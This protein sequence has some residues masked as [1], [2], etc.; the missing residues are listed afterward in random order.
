MDR[1]AQA[2]A[3]PPSECD[4][5]ARLDAEQRAAGARGDYS[6]G[7]DYR[8]LLRRHRAAAH[9]QQPEPMWEG[10]L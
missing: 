1:R 10:A 2:P 6:R 9:Q 7:V 8:V 3:A 5:C 4:K